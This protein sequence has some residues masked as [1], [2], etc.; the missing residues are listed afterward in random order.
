[1][2]METT[3]TKSRDTDRETAKLSKRKLFTKAKSPR[4]WRHRGRDQAR[5]AHRNSTNHAEEHE[6]K[7]P[8]R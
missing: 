1:M 7:K 8:P 5:K 3:P 6:E 4:K 2:M